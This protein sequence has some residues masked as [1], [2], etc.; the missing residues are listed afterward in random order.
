MKHSPSTFKLVF[1]GEPGAGKTTCISALSD[2]P[3]V[4]TE[5]ECTDALTQIKKTTT[6]ALDYGEMDLGD[7]GRLLL[8]GLPGQTRFNFMMNVVKENLV[9]IVL[10]VDAQ[11]RS[12][13]EGLTATLQ[14]HQEALSENPFVVV[15]NKSQDDPYALR[16][17]ATMVLRR[18]RMV[19]P[20]LSMDVRHRNELA[21]IFDLLFLCAEHA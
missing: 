10:L 7:Q 4:S 11:S 2:F 14:A 18:H 9:G 6:V 16:Q 13:I 17:Q 8:Y 12:P 21:G 19:A 3:V 15:V 5:V 1:I 20:T